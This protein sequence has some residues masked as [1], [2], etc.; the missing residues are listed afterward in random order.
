MEARFF[1]GKVFEN[2][3]PI[4]YEGQMSLASEW[5]V[6]LIDRKSEKE[7]KLH[8]E[9]LPFTPEIELTNDCTLE[10]EEAWF[11]LPE[12]YITAKIPELIVKLKF[13]DRLLKVYK[14]DFCNQTVYL[15]WVKRNADMKRGD[16]FIHFSCGDC[17]DTFVVRMDED[18]RVFWRE[19]F[20]VGG[21]SFTT[22]EFLG[23]DEVVEVFRLVH[24]ALKDILYINPAWKEIFKNLWEV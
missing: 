12:K 7:I 2:P 15:K 19:K 10:E 6:W 13:G 21:D 16:T 9:S 8:V 18:G 23:E 22:F 11:Y 20:L 1:I 24:E 14:L 17:N 4:A 3:I 5:L